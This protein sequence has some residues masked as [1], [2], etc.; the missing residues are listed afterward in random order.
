MTMTYEAK[1][2]YKHSRDLADNNKQIHRYAKKAE[3]LEVAEK[4]IKAGFAKE[5]L[6]KLIEE[7][8]EIMK[9]IRHHYHKF[10]TY[11]RKE[12]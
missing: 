11:V 3:R 6:Q 1:E 5:K 2:L 12:H 8:K 4:F 10:H 9:R 7:H